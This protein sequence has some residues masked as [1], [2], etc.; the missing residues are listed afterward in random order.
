MFINTIV[1]ANVILAPLQAEEIETVNNKISNA[2]SL[3]NQLPQGE[4]APLTLNSA[5]RKILP[6][7][8][9]ESIDPLLLPGSKTPPQ[10]EDLPSITGLDLLH[11]SASAQPAEGEFQA[12][13][14]HYA[15][16]DR[17][18]TVVNL[19]EESALF[20]N[21][22]A[23]SVFAATNLGNMGKTLD[24]ISEEERVLVE[25]L[26]KQK[27]VTIYKIIS[28]T[29]L[30]TLDEREPVT[31]IIDRIATEQELVAN[32]GLDY[33]RLP[34][35]DHMRPSDQA[36]EAFVSAVIQRGAESHFHFHCWEGHGR[37]TTVMIMLDAMMNADKVSFVDIW[38]RQWWLGG[39]GSNMSNVPAKPIY[40]HELFDERF[41]FLSTFYRYCQ[42]NRKDGFQK[43]WTQYLNENGISHFNP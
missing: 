20:I 6:R 22:H 10:E 14:A 36:V 8:F 12:L 2:I 26:R 21:G 31:M 41:Q 13:G 16:G 5:D 17:R 39:E 37:T 18:V 11:A 38:K 29:A 30:D 28:K 9:R 42:K 40:K 23:I 33:L 3:L 7:H 43:S 24:Q 15:A 27:D 19:R 32:A 34:M 25:S 1:L 35:T 4:E